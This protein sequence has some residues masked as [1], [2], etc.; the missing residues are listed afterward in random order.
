MESL[1]EWVDDGIY[2]FLQSLEEAEAPGFVV[3][4]TDDN[5]NGTVVAAK[6]L[7]GAGTSGYFPPEEL[8]KAQATTLRVAAAHANDTMGTCAR[9]SNPT[10]ACAIGG[11]W[12]DGIGVRGGGYSGSLGAVG[13]TMPPP[14]VVLWPF[15][16]KREPFVAGQNRSGAGGASTANSGGTSR[17]RSG[18]GPGEAVSCSSSADTSSKGSP[19]TR[20]LLKNNESESA[21]AKS[22]GK[23][24][25]GACSAR[26]AD[27]GEV[28]SSSKGLLNMRCRLNTH[29]IETTGAKDEGN[30]GARGGGRGRRHDHQR[31]RNNGR[32]VGKMF[33][34]KRTSSANA[35]NKDTGVG[36]N[37]M[38]TQWLSLPLRWVPGSAP[39]ASRQDGARGQGASGGSSNR[40]RGDRTR[41][42]RSTGSDALDPVRESTAEVAGGAAARVAGRAVAATVV[43]VAGAANKRSDEVTAAEAT[44]DGA[45]Q[46]SVSRSSALVAAPRP[47]SSRVKRGYETAATKRGAAQQKL[48]EEDARSGWAGD[49]SSNERQ[50]KRIWRRNRRNRIA[51]VKARHAAA[52][53]SSSA[54]ANRHHAVG[55]AKHDE[56]AS[57]AVSGSRVAVKAKHDEVAEEEL[58]EMI[59]TERSEG[60]SLEVENKLEGKDNSA[61]DTHKTVVDN[62]ELGKW[63][64]V[65]SDTDHGGGSGGGGFAAAA[66][67]CV[68]VFCRSLGNGV[69]AGWGGV[70]T[71]VCGVSLTAFRVVGSALNLAVILQRRTRHAVNAIVAAAATTGD[72]EKLATSAAAPK[73][74]WTSPFPL[75]KDDPAPSA[76]TTA[77]GDTTA[78]AGTIGKGLGLGDQALDAVAARAEE[79][80]NRSSSSTAG[81]SEGGS[82]VE[83][84]TTTAAGLPSSSKPPASNSKGL[85]GIPRAT[86]KAAA[87]R[88]AGTREWSLGSR[89]QA[90]SPRSKAPITPTTAES[91][92]HNTI[93]TKSRLV[94]QLSDRASYNVPLS[95]HAATAAISI[96][97]PYPPAVVPATTDARLASSATVPTVVT[98]ETKSAWALTVPSDGVPKRSGRRSRLLI[99]ATA[100]SE[101]LAMPPATPAAAAHGVNHSVGA[102]STAAVLTRA[103]RETAALEA[104]EVGAARP[105]PRKKLRR[106]IGLA[107]YLP[108]GL[109]SG[110]C[111]KK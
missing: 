18:D 42:S 11:S 95:P 32:G 106:A 87:G 57:F 27:P 108:L 110:R 10:R 37:E 38:G 53:E 76:A 5:N 8:A 43:F 97:S 94:N 111:G 79:T 58:S 82:T 66:G 74:N 19:N 91:G 13:G 33:S 65:P 56:A 103:L 89:P 31:N 14:A 77:I 34:G 51:T 63:V 12:A 54:A 104:M 61:G 93:S 2:L 80:A 26:K 21:E 73:Y 69:S 35:A 15:P 9:A 39:A 44:S 100:R 67:R 20:D 47:S 29:K 16:K 40:S 3:H 28:F 99:G 25:A 36:K 52:K 102:P 41:R 62:G 75:V 23:S 72:G 78:L 88:T 101:K 90:G 55:K 70:A 64:V 59:A 68:R 22:R 45:R 1:G 86:A 71:A 60:G 50:Q 6:S 85:L 24:N 48:R 30:G 84:T 83:R 4:H 49:S 98:P 96:A 17:T 109:K 107:V 81:I 105:P 46:S 92:G 7:R